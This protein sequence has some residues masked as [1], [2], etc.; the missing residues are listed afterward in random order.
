MAASIRAPA[1]SASL[2]DGSSTGTWRELFIDRDQ[3]CAAPSVATAVAAGHSLLVIDAVATASEC[4][5]IASEACQAAACERATRCHSVVRRPFC[6]L[7][8]LVR[9]PVATLVSAEC[10]TLC[11]NLL[12][13]QLGLLDVSA[14][15]LTRDLFGEVLTSAQTTCFHNPGLTWTDGEPA[16]NVYTEG[17]SFTA[18]EDEQSLTCLLNL[19][20]QGAYT[21]GGTAFWSRDDAG[22]DR[23]L[24]DI[25]PPTHLIAPPAGTAIIFGGSVTHAARPVVSGER[26]VLVASLSPLSGFKRHGEGMRLDDRANAGKCGHEHKPLVRSLS[27]KTRGSRQAKDDHPL[28]QLHLAGTTIPVAT[29]ALPLQTVSL[30]PPFTTSDTAS[31]LASGNGVVRHPVCSLEELCAAR[32]LDGKDGSGSGSDARGSGKGWSRSER[33]G[34]GSER[35]SSGSGR[36]GSGSERDG[37]GSVRD[38][39]GSERDGRGS[40]RDGS[41]SRTQGVAVDLEEMGTGREGARELALTEDESGSESG[42]DGVGK[43]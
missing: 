8:G 31:V 10:T 39:S 27:M 34:S 35:D 22:K 17:G 5:A 15:S 9:K 23:S 6:F 12:L 29:A 20:E 2:V 32:R 42:W 14:P 38:G 7:A 19:S 37:I 16:I 18:H 13:R 30:L 1:T 4:A 43:R 24:C 28:S 41:G 25:N 33:D 40:G 26:I 3:A 21:G 36:D 11:D